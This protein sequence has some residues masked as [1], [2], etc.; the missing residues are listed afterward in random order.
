MPEKAS[1][2]SKAGHFVELRRKSSDC[3]L[4]CEKITQFN[5]QEEEKKND[6][7]YAICLFY[8]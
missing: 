7:I 4:N 6:K 8:L 5:C 2:T 1:K 3:C